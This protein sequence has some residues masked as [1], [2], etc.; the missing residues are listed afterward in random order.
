MVL[1]SNVLHGERPVGLVLFSGWGGFVSHRVLVARWLVCPFSG[2]FVSRGFGRVWCV[3]CPFRGRFVNPMVSERA[4]CW[5]C[6]LR[7][8]R[9]C[10][11]WDLGYWPRP[12]LG[13]ENG[14]AK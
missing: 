13:G 2:F 10:A 1:E 11:F 6:P 12:A 9:L 14:G 5:F 8:R 3:I 7:L 4:R